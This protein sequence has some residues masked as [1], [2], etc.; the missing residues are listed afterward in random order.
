MC[1]CRR[2][3]RA[4]LSESGVRASRSSAVTWVMDH[5]IIDQLARRALGL[6]SRSL[7]LS[8]SLSTTTLHPSR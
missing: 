1:T 8:L 4:M 6:G 2:E 5:I 7:S 3:K